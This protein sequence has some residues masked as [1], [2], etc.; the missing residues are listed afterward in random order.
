MDLLHRLFRGR[1][2][3]L[4]PFEEGDTVI[5]LDPEGD[6]EFC[7]RLRKGGS[8]NLHKGKILFDDILGKGDGAIIYSS[9]GDPFVVYRPTL[10]QFIMHM[11]RDTQIIYPKDIAFILLYADVYP[12]ATVLEAGI[13]SGALTLGLLRAVGDKGRVISYEVREEFVKR[14]LK[15]IRQFLG[16][17]VPNLKVELLDIYEGI[18]EE[19]IDRLLLD[20]PEPWRVVE[21]ASK[22]LRPGGIFLSYLP[23]I[24]QV[25]TLVDTLR[26]HPAFTSIETME[27]LV[28][29]WNIEGLSVR[30]YHR[31]VGHTGFLTLARRSEVPEVR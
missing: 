5:L 15:N 4:P 3:E 10:R 9:R 13:G 28:R 29:N 26:E 23:T 17:E 20:V 7:Y 18:H 8:V 31:M 22:A 25:K 21:H 2:E 1:K 27:I 30:P 11:R 24:I 12:G 14:A 6:K 19:G 16:P